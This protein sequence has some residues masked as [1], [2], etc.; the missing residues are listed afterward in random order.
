MPFVTQEPKVRAE[1]KLRRQVARR[2]EEILAAEEVV[3]T[4]LVARAGIGSPGF[5]RLLGRTAE[6]RLSIPAL[7]KL[8]DALG[9]E[10]EI[11]IT[12]KERR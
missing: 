2:L 1:A 10:V 9:Y 5:Y 6:D 11:L 12:K 4:D 8:A 7:V 3:V